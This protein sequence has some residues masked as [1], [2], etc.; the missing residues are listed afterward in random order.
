MRAE[1]RLRQ[2]S[3]RASSC[4]SVASPELPRSACS[5]LFHTWPLFQESEA[6]GREREA[7][8]RRLREDLKAQARW[9]GCWLGCCLCPRKGCTALHPDWQHGS[10]LQPRTNCA[11]LLPTP[12]LLQKAKL[13]AAQKALRESEVELEALRA[14]KEVRS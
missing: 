7:E 10:T 11:P 9:E 13:H 3:R 8:F 4:G 12:C 6:A 2:A 14:E 5:H 1:G